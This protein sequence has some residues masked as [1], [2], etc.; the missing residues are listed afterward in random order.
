MINRDQI[1]E[2]FKDKVGFSNGD[3]GPKAEI[4]LG[5]G[6][7]LI[8]MEQQQ[9]TFVEISGKRTV[10]TGVKSIEDLIQLAKLISD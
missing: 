7:Y 3:Q 8:Y 10:A 9:F 6:V 4:Q 5:F 2:H 1:I